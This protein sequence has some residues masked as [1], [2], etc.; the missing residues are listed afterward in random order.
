MKGRYARQTGLS[1][2]GEKSVEVL[3]NTKMVV[4]GAGGVGSALLPILAGAGV[5]K[6][7]V[8][9]GDRVSISNL[10]RQTLYTEKQVGQSKARLAAERLSSINSEV[11][12]SVFEK[13]LN[14]REDVLE[15]LK[16]ADMCI[17]ASDNFKTR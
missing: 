5:G 15:I 17:D 3:K 10:H 14:S 7:L 8:A 1:G 12:I 9:D 4:V 13:F 11:E 2:F 16:G 6:I